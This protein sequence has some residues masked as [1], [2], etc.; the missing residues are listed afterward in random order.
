MVSLNEGNLPTRPECAIVFFVRELLAFL[1]T[2]VL[3]SSPLIH[4]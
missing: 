4:L 1:F 3:L 2:V